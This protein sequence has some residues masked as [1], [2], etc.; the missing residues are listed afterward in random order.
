M[1][2]LSW[3]I[4]PLVPWDASFPSD[5]HRGVHRDRRRVAAC[6]EDPHASPWEEEDRRGSSGEDSPDRSRTPSH[7]S[8]APG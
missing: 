3:D 8:L 6:W 5:D 4:A 2:I 7:G 1:E